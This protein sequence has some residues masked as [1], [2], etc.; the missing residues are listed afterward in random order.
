MN[1]KV[2][3]SKGLNI[4]CKIDKKSYKKFIEEI[5]LLGQKYE[6]Q[7]NVNKLDY[8]INISCQRHPFM[9]IAGWSS[10]VRESNGRST[11]VFFIDYDNC[12]FSLIQ[13]EIRYIQEKYDMP[14]FYCF[15]TFEEKDEQGNLFG[16]Y[17]LICLGKKTFKEVIDIQEEL[18]CDQAFKVIPKINRFKTF[19]LRI[20]KKGKK[21]APKFKCVIGDLAK[22]YP[23]DVS[24][25]HLEALQT[26]YKDLPIVNYSNLD[27]NHID[28]LYF[29]TY[30]TSST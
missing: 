14:I 6:S 19:C 25:G 29:D 21:D 8:S 4:L 28:K 26:I 12:Y 11:E 1:I 23:Q 13:D 30:W 18:H 16:N 24:Q 22:P 3:D 2:K 15:T 10:R 7:S 20:G 27:G 17:L 5:K 9:K